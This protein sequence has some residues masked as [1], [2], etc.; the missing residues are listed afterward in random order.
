MVDALRRNAITNFIATI[1]NYK[2]GLEDKLEEG[3]K[4]D[5]KYQSLRE[6]ITQNVCEN[7][8]TNYSLNEKVLILYKNR[9]Y[10]PNIPEVKL[11]ILNEVHKSPYSRHLGYQKMITVWIK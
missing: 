4:M 6:K 10:M 9:L 5:T 2:T 3:I 11:L 1:S 7:L 8:I